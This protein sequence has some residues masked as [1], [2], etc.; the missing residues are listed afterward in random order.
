MNEYTEGRIK[1]E[2]MRPIQFNYNEILKSNGRCNVEY[3][4]V[5]EIRKLYP[6]RW[7]KEKRC[8]R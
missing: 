4:T 6:K 3:L 8:E 2:T 5:K 7:K 1:F